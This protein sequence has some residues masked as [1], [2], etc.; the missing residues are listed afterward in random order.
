MPA[1]RSMP[2]EMPRDRVI[3]AARAWIGT[4][5]HHQAS[6]RDVGADCLGLIRGVWRDLGGP[7]IKPDRRYSPFWA[8]RTDD[9]ALLEAFRRHLVEAGPDGPAPGR[10]LVFRPRPGFAA[11]HAVIQTAADAMIHAYEA[12]GVVETPIGGWWRRHLVAVFAFPENT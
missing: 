12:R 3:A 5:Y 8:E 4:P 9:E 6:L 2:L 1:V 10:V 7:D 11:K